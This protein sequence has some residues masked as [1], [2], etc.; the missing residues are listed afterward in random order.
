MYENISR[1]LI[2]N[3]DI[4]QGTHAVYTHG[5]YEKYKRGLVDAPITYMLYTYNYLTQ[6]FVTV[7]SWP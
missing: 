6:I 3:I 5:F 4:D 7:P 1:K 2:R